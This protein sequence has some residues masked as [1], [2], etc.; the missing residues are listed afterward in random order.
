MDLSKL[1]KR[2]YPKLQEKRVLRENPKAPLHSF[3]QKLDKDKLA[4]KYRKALGG[5]YEPRQRAE[6]EA[7]PPTLDKWKD[8]TND[9]KNWVDSRVGL[10][11]YS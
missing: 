5:T 9:P 4:E 10:A 8:T 1:N 3:A 6:N 7:L 11:R 2:D